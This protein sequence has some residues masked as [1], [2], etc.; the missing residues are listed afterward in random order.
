MLQNTECAEADLETFYSQYAPSVHMVYTYTHHY[1][2]LYKKIVEGEISKLASDTISTVLSTV[3]SFGTK[4][5]SHHIFLVSP[6]SDCT[7]YMITIPTHYI[8]KMLCNHLHV[9]T[10]QEAVNLYQIFVCNLHIKTSADYILDDIHN[11]FCKG[12]EWEVTLLT[13]NKVRPV[14]THFKSPSQDTESSYMYLG[15][16]GDIVKIT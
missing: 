2:L 16:N 10:L 6:Q 1:L 3:V 13:K 4:G 5:V 8:Y 9:K 15:Y 12:G 11:L 14:N 7:D